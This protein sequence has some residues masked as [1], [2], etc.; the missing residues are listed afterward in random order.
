MSEREEQ[1]KSQELRG[2]GRS[3]L[4]GDGFEEEGGE[5]R[6]MRSYRRGFEMLFGSGACEDVVRNL[7]GR[8]GERLRLTRSARE[9]RRQMGG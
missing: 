4:G 5:G 1:G 8:R 7:E 6:L 2:V 9:K 3:G